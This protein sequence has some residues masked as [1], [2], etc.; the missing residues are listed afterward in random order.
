M[1]EYL[2]IP[3]AAPNNKYCWA[4]YKEDGS[5][6]RFLW[7]KNSGWCRFGTRYHLFTKDDPEY[8]CAVDIF[9]GKYAADIEHLIKNEK[10]FRHCREVICFCE[11]FGPNSFAGQ[12]E[13]SDEK[14]LVLFDVNVHK[15]GLLPPAEFV[16]TFSHLHIP[17]IIYQGNLTAEF[18]RDV[19]NGMYPVKEGVVCKGCDGKPPHGIWMMKIKTNAYREE[20]VKRYH[21]NWMK[22]WE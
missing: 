19:R 12:H 20:L 3:S 10:Y 21:A 18:I 5:N 11:F 2:S 13:P 15:K 16:K 6:L 17:E 14:D 1:K 22:F 8:G 4:F 7:T 9:M